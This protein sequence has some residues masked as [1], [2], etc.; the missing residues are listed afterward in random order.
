[1]GLGGGGDILGRE[2][3]RG[4]V[5]FEN[6]GGGRAKDSVLSYREGLGCEGLR[7]ECGERAKRGRCESCVDDYGS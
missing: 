2:K 3:V 1:M 7:R 6:I 5:G 4:G